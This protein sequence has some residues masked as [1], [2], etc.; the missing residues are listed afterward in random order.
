MKIK[1]EESKEEDTLIVSLKEWPSGVGVYVRLLEEENLHLLLWIAEGGI[2][3]QC[4][5]PPELGIAL[6]DHKCVVL[7]EG[8]GPHIPIDREDSPENARVKL[9]RIAHSQ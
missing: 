5:L 1:T 2:L 7:N 9:A 8:D 6:T 4:G 3:R